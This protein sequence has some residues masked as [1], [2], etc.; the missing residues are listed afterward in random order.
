MKKNSG[1]KLNKIQDKTIIPLQEIKETEENSN[2][3]NNFRN[4]K[5]EPMKLK[6]KEDPHKRLIDQMQLLVGNKPKPQL[7]SPRRKPFITAKIEIDCSSSTNSNMNST[8]RSM[9]KFDDN[10]NDNNKS[11]SQNL[12]IFNDYIRNQIISEFTETTEF[13]EKLELSRYID[14]FIQNGLIDMNRIKSNFYY[15][16]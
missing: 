11:Y 6:L 14:V 10:E 13:L 8:N 15:L 16:Y 5:L 1:L 9:I 4:K 2:T 12:N 7:D 3:T